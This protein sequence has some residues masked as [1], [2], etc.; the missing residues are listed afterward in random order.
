MK[1]ASL[2][3]FSATT[4]TPTTCLRLSTRPCLIKIANRHH[5]LQQRNVPSNSRYA[6]TQS[7]NKHKVW[8]S[9]VQARLGKCMTHGTSS[10]ETQ[11]AG[12]ILKDITQNW[13]TYVAGG[14]AFLTDS[15]WVGLDRQKVVWG[16]MVSDLP[17]WLVSSM[18]F[19]IVQPLERSVAWTK[20]SSSFCKF[21]LSVLT[22]SIRYQDS[23]VCSSCFVNLWSPWKL[24]WQR[25]NARI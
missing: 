8:L 6:S 19:L 2:R 7:D 12:E 18:C 17:L 5:Q 21:R 4:Y 24:W 1:S 11:K 16:D 10:E 25:Y 20:T 3:L 23:M 22:Y 14:S 15:K 13:R 9:D